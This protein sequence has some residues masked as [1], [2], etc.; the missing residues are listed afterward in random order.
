M[1]VYNNTLLAEQLTWKVFT[2]QDKCG[3]TTCIYLT[4]ILATI[5]SVWNMMHLGGPITTLYFGKTK[6]K[7]KP[8]KDI[9][10]V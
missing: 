7:N 3:F 8:R 9:I 5:L 6:T 4:H 10:G 2:C 1:Y